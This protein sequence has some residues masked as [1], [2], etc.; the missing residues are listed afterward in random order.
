MRPTVAHCEQANEMLPTK[1]T[2][3]KFRLRR[4]R[5]EHDGRS[6]EANSRATT[7]RRA[8]TEDTADRVDQPFLTRLGWTLSCRESLAYLVVILYDKMTTSWTVRTIAS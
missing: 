2:P 6:E 5:K 8:V 3:A 1:L 4:H 7:T